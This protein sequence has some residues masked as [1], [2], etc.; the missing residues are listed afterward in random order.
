MFDLPV[1]TK[2]E[3]KI[4]STFRKELL[5]DGYQMMQFS[6]YMR[7]CQDYER[8]KKHANRVRAFAPKTGNIRVVF[9]TDKQW[10]KSISIVSKNYMRETKA[11][12]PKMQA[13][14]EF[15]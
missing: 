3:R 4:A 12:P 7:A 1:T 14:F 8:M 6:I 5:D 13:V 9:I 11:E 10:I 15:W 2:R